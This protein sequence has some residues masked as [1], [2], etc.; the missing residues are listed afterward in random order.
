MTKKQIIDGYIQA[1]KPYEVCAHTCMGG[2]MEFM[3][4]EQGIMFEE[5]AKQVADTYAQTWGK[6]N[7][8]KGVCVRK[9]GIVIYE[10]AI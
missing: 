7:N 9:Q 4:L 1:E 10:V 5:N 2:Y 8:I 3:R 6:S